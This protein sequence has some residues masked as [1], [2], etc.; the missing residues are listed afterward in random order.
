MLEYGIRISYS[1]IIEF[2]LKKVLTVTTVDSKLE[3]Q[4]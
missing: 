1:S 2:R 4:Y 3:N